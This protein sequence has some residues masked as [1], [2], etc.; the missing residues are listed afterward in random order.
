MVKCF[1]FEE[2]SRI[3]DESDVL[4]TEWALQSV[5]VPGMFIENLCCT[6]HARKVYLLRPMPV[7][8]KITTLIFLKSKE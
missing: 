8:N 6:S 2:R 3:T 5:T 4:K 1:K 7:F